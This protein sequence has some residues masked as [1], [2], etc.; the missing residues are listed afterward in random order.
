MGSGNLSCP[1]GSQV[2]PSVIL[3]FSQTTEITAVISMVRPPG[4]REREVEGVGGDGGV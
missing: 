3:A 2:L 1:L 4:K